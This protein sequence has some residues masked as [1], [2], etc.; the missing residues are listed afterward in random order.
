M[1]NIAIENIVGT[2]TRVTNA[3]YY[4]ENRTMSVTFNT[5]PD[6]DCGASVELKDRIV[7]ASLTGTLDANIDFDVTVGQNDTIT[8]TVLNAYP[9]NSTRMDMVADGVKER[10]QRKLANEF[11]E[12]ITEMRGTNVFLWYS[13]ES[14]F[15]NNLISTINNTIAVML[16]N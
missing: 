7:M 1:D 2:V 13:F 14:Y 11:V 9:V 6:M 3:T 4:A 10:R 16:E 12:A 5:K 15:Q 8:V